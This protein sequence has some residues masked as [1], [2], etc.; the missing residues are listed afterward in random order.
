MKNDNEVEGYFIVDMINLSH[1]CTFHFRW[2]L[3][4]CPGVYVYGVLHWG[5]MISTRNKSSLTQTKNKTRQ[6]THHFHVYLR[7]KR[8]LVPV[9][10]SAHWPYVKPTATATDYKY[11]HQPR[12]RPVSRSLDTTMCIP[13]KFEADK[14]MP[15]GAYKKHIRL[16]NPRAWGEG[17]WNH[18][19]TLALDKNVQEVL[20]TLPVQ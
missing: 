3:F 1:Q 6:I 19:H 12:H 14:C 10:S 4:L 16:I 17:R 2:F 7:W 5:D 18:N 20:T 13:G 9:L 11:K 8:L 15:S